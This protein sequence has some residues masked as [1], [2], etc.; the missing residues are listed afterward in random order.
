MYTLTVKVLESVSSYGQHLV[1]SDPVL[2][3]V[4]VSSSLVCTCAF[5]FARVH[6]QKLEIAPNVRTDIEPCR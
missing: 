6:S 4:I 5:T 3:H 2:L 1:Y